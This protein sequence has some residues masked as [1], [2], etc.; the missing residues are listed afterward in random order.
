[1][2]NYGDDFVLQE[3]IQQHVTM[4]KFCSSSV[5]TLR[6]ATYKSIIDDTVHILGAV[7]RIGLEGNIVDNA[8]AGGLFIGI[9]TKSGKVGS[10]LY[11]SYGHEKTE[12]NGVNF[13][14]NSFYIHNWEGV[15][16]LAKYV[17]GQ[18]AHCRLLALDIAVDSS[19]IPKLIELNCNS[20]SYWLYMYT[21][22]TPFGAFTDE[23]INYCIKNLDKRIVKMIV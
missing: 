14:N 18:N 11:D 9:D 13:T 22:H 5:N 8:H 19:G 4:S 2:L 1:M 23:I 17:G 3:A 21:G 16:S 12:I 10:M 20:F 6:L 15:I 7:M